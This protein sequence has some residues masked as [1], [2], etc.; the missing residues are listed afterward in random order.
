[1][2]THLHSLI[3]NNYRFNQIMESK[4]CQ[5]FEQTISLLQNNV[6]IPCYAFTGPRMWCSIRPS[7]MVKESFIHF[8]MSTNSVQDTLFAQA[9]CTVALHVGLQYV[10]QCRIQM[11]VTQLNEENIKKR[12]RSHLLTQYLLHI[13]LSTN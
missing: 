9:F 3:P 12:L 6:Q 4:G 10:V 1:M 7:I 5:L 2:K 8:C 13:I 11:Y